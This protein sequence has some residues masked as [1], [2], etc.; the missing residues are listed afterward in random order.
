MLRGFSVSNFKSFNDTQTI[1]LAASKIVRHKDHVVTIANRKILK[2]G[3]IFGANAGG[4]SNLI[5]A[6]DFSRDIIMKGIDNVDLNKKY[7]R[8]APN[9]FNRPAVFEYDIIANGK[10]YSY[11]IAISYAKREIISEWLVRIDKSGK[12]FTIFNRN[13]D[14]NGTSVVETDVE[15]EMKPNSKSSNMRLHVYFEDFGEDIAPALRKKTILSDIASRSNDKRGI[16]SEIIHVYEWFTNMIIIFPDSKYNLINEIA[17]NDDRREFFQNILSFFDTG[18]ESISKQQRSMDFDKVLADFPRE[19]ADQIKI[20]LSKIANEHPVTFRIGKQAIILRK[21]SDGNIIYNK[22]VLNHGNKDDPFEYADESDGTQRLFDL[23]PLLYENNEPR[24]IFIDEIDRSLHTNVCRKFIELFFE[25]TKN[26][27]SQLIATTHD[28]NIMDLDLLRQDEIW[29]VE[30]EEDH[31]SKLY[32]LNKF[33]A[34]FDKVV[35][36][37]YLIGRYGAI[38]LFHGIFSTE[39]DALN[40][41]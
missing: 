41:E 2:S 15:K 37:D 31:S 27:D 21:D 17:S 24:V 11:G 28:S 39:V 30:R 10:E 23:V 4:K 3:I 33:K 18:I 7:F 40:E 29:F 22:L 35:K 5:K 36:N 16:L 26:V 1:S 25:L 20:E 6:I 13:V 34:R 9:S 32:S 14:D 12:E 38:P 19:Q 8:I